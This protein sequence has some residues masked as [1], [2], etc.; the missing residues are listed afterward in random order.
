[1]ESIWDSGK[2]TSANFSWVCL[3]LSDLWIKYRL[4]S[5]LKE[6]HACWIPYSSDTAEW[7][8]KRHTFWASVHRFPQNVQFH[9]DALAAQS[10]Q[11]LPEVCFKSNK[12]RPV[13]KLS[14]WRPSF[15]HPCFFES[16]KNIVFR[17]RKMKRSKISNKQIFRDIQDIS[18]RVP[19]KPPYEPLPFNQLTNGRCVSSKPSRPFQTKGACHRH[20]GGIGSEAHQANTSRSR[21][22]WILVVCSFF[23]GKNDPVETPKKKGNKSKVRKRKYCQIDI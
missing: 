14:R 3:K 12:T 22:G 9:D 15:F 1:M 13:P 11:T 21:C 6:T 4:M 8:I 17:R 10:F 19:S 7:P 23:G 16:G 2:G 18:F 5:L 20:F